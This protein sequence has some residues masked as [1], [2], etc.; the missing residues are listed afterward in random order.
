MC[1]R[2]CKECGLP[3][4]LRPDKGVPFAT[5]TLARLSPLSAWWVRLG[6]LPAFIA[7]GNPQ[8]N[9][10]HERRH[11]TR[12][13][14]TTRPPAATRR[15]QPRTFDR[16]RQACNCERPHEALAMPTPAARDE[17][18]SRAMPPKLPPWEDPHRFEVRDVRAT[19]GIRWHHH[20]VNVSH[21][22]GGEY[23]GREELD[24]GVWHV[25]CGPLQLGRFRERHRRIEDA[26]GRLTRRR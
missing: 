18:S 10:R 7:P 22:C 1:T 21:P 15:A 19:G 20:G 3:K 26:Y 17:V 16:F 4:R 25:D 23:V 2:V 8:Q 5:R 6:L 14:E 13:A 11:R 12:N 24:D 9:G